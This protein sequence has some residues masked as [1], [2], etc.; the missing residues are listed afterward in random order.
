MRSRGRVARSLGRRK[1]L[2]PELSIRQA[3]DIV[4]TLA[5]ERTYLALVRDREWKAEDYERWL[6]EQLVASLLENFPLRLTRTA[7]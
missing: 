1:H 4:W 7:R 6:H 2:R 3:A 5:S